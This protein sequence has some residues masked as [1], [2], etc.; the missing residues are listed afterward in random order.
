[1][2][3]KSDGTAEAWGGSS[4]CGDSGTSLDAQYLP[5]A[6]Q[7]N[8]CTATD[9][10]TIVV[11]TKKCST[12]G[13]NVCGAGKIYDATKANEDCASSPC[14]AGGSDV[15][16][17]CKLD[18]IPDKC[19]TIA[20][21]PAYPSKLFLECQLGLLPNHPRTNDPR[22]RRTSCQCDAICHCYDLS[23]VLPK[24]YPFPIQQF[25]CIIFFDCR[26]YYHSGDHRKQ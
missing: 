18:A 14:V 2:A 24:Q 7:T 9:C 13:A 5:C 6:D 26:R 23:R 3:R 15:D 10:C 19:S 20:S 11:A 1:M 4:R 17:C 21:S 16:T 12:A 22:R 25:H 8:G